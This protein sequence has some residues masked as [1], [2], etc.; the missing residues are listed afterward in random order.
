MGSSSGSSAPLT[1]LSPR[2]YDVFVSFYGDDTRKNFTDHLFGALKRKNI[3]AFRD[4]RHLNGGEPI[5][6]GLFRAIEGS[7]IFIVVFSKNYADSTWCLREL[8]HIFLHRG[9]PSEKRVWTFFY[10]VD[11]SVVRKQSDSYQIAFAKHETNPNIDIEMLYRWKL[12]LTQAANITGCDL[13]HKSQYAAIEKFVQEIVDMFGYNFSY[14]PNDLVGML[15]PIEELEKLLLLDSV[16]NVR[17]VGIYGMSGVGKTTLASVLYGKMKNSPQ[18]DACC[19]IDDVSKSFRQY[20]PFD[21]QKQI[22]HQI[23][24][25]EHNQIFNL[26]DAAN[27]MQSRLCRHRVLII[28]DNVDHNEQLEK[29]AL[30]RKLLAAGSRIIVVCRDLHVLKE[31]RMDE[32]YEVPLLSDENSFQL[33]CQKAFED[34][35][36]SDYEELTYAILNYANGLPLAIK[37]LGSFLFSRCVSEWTSALARL[38]ENPN[39][40]IMDALKFSFYGLED[41][42]KEIFLD[43][44]CFFNMSEEKTVKNIL[45]CCG[46]HPDIGLRVLIDKSLISISKESKVEMHGLLEELGRK[47]VQQNSTEEARKWSRVWLHK[48][49]SDVMS[50]NM[51]KNVEAI[52][53]KGNAQDTKKLTAEALSTMFRLRLLKLEDVEVLGNLTNL[54]NQLRYVAWDGYPFMHLPTSFQPNHLVELI[55]KYSNIEQLWNDKKINLPN[56]RTLDLSFSEN[57]MTMSDFG[58]VP[59]LERLNLEG[60]IKL[61]E[62]NLSTGLPKKLVFM[63]LKNCISLKCIPNGISG[64]NSLEYLNLCSCSE[65]FNNPRDLEFPSLASFDG[66]REVDISFCSLSH[67]PGDIGGLR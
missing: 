29:L 31:Y 6:P 61:V 7:Q 60:C 44:A 18:F 58:V 20:G 10:D 37:V 11:P 56:L 9:Q 5:A 17:T 38:R 65:A 4:N 63:N 23:L 36:D 3:V 19:F 55:L 22:L 59:N 40:D 8:E 1:T 32:F 43:I 42:E 28:F 52:V 21:V 49:C 51:E 67:L 12:V 53:L 13:L 62:M 50:E 39:K 66:L 26:Y 14:R 16:D 35:I 34:H 48:H 41:K 64:L 2:K 46:F 30:N 57:L 47:I 45:N 27:L 24:G 25:E 54:S 33:F 15:S